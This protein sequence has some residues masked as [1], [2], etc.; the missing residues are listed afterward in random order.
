MMYES[1]FVI[2]RII[3]V[4]IVIAISFFL[5]YKFQTQ[6]IEVVTL[7][8]VFTITTGVPGGLYYPLGITICNFVNEKFSEEVVCIATISEGSADNLKKLQNKE[9]DIAIVQSDIQFHSYHQTPIYKGSIPFVPTLRSVSSLHIEP[10]TALVRDDEDTITTIEDVEN[11]KIN[12]GP[13]GSSTYS[14]VLTLFH[15]LGISDT[16]VLS[17]ISFE[18]QAAALCNGEIDVAFYTVSHPHSLIQEALSLCPL[19]FVN[20]EGAEVDMLVT[21]HPYYQYAAVNKNAYSTEKGFISFGVGA[22]LVSTDDVSDT[23][24]ARVIESILIHKDTLMK[25]YPQLG[26]V[27]KESLKGQP[28]TAPLHKAAAVFLK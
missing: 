26:E 15:A 20:I 21:L 19:T 14:V 28:L 16:T 24:I 1:I 5:Y 12:A 22:T 2:I 8:A 9:S 10:L 11:K 3:V 18:E 23:V 25:L 27:S 13:V 17:N 4:T 7:P 6:D